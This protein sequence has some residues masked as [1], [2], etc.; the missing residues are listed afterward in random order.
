MANFLE[1]Y[2]QEFVD[3]DFERIHLFELLRKEYG[4]SK[5]LYLGSHIHIA[6]SLVYPTVVYV[7]S[8]K[9]AAKLFQDKQLAEYVEKNKKY[10][11]KST[12]EFIYRNYDKE[13]SINS[14]F[15]LLI[16]QYAGFV[17]QAGKKY[18]K[19]G[20]ILVANN[21]HGDASMTHL[22]DDYELIAV[23]NHTSDKWRISTENLDDYF[24]PKN[25]KP[26]SVVELRE[27]MR[28]FGY[29]KTAANYIFRKP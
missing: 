6:P 3:K 7:D 8:Y 28:G 1:S 2:N 14:D 25:G 22:D 9:R 29:T 13:L 20:G 16:S 15:D 19:S 18:L 24:I 17:S 5:A 23:S 21:S 26:D 11:E 12:I 27:I 4:G 10:E